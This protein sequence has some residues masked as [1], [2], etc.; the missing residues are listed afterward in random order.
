M[1]AQG[2]AAITPLTGLLVNDLDKDGVPLCP[3]ML[4]P[5]A[6]LSRVVAIRQAD[7]KR[8]M[9]GAQDL[10]THCVSTRV[11]PPQDPLTKRPFTEEEMRRISVAAEQVPLHV[12]LRER[13]AEIQLEKQGDAL[14]EELQSELSKQCRS[15]ASKVPRIW[16]GKVAAVVHK[17]VPAAWHALHN[18]MLFDS[19]SSEEALAELVRSIEDHAITSD[20]QH[21]VAGMVGEMYEAMMSTLKGEEPH[22]AMDT[23][24][25]IQNGDRL[26]QIRL[27]RR[28]GL[29]LDMV[30]SG[31]D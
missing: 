21:M 1:E 10:Y 9:Y 22:T 16:Q 28:T 29:T 11:L 13:A 23:V 27:E 15:L 8:V 31:E 6:D 4:E 2:S 24:R 3:L 18:I 20:D 14:H 19:D 25:N 5:L 12:A 30:G 17:T 7:G 26:L